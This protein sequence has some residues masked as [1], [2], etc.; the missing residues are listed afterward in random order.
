MTDGDDYVKTSEI[1][2]R[3]QH[4]STAVTRAWIRKHGLEAKYRDI[5][6]GEKLYPRRQVERAIADSVIRGP[7]RKDR[8]SAEGPPHDHDPGLP[9]SEA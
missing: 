4:A 2:A 9:G 1:A 7:Y 6:T 3:L 5:D 8:P